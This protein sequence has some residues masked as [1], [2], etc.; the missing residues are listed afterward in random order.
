MEDFL[1]GSKASVI[2]LDKGVEQN[3]KK[4]YTIDYNEGLLS[5]ILEIS[6]STQET[7]PI[8][9][10]AQQVIFN[11]GPTVHG[12]DLRIPSDLTLTT[13]ETKI[14]LNNESKYFTDVSGSGA[15]FLLTS[16]AFSRLNSLFQDSITHYL[17]DSASNKF[18]L[19]IKVPSISG[20]INPYEYNTNEFGLS[21]VNTFELDMNSMKI[22][23]GSLRIES[24]FKSYSNFTFLNKLSNPAVT[25]VSLPTAEFFL[26]FTTSG[27]SSPTHLNPGNHFV[28]YKL[29]PTPS[30]LVN[31]IKDE[32]L[33][34]GI[35]ENGFIVIP[36]N[37]DPKIKYN[38]TK[39]LKDQLGVEIETG[40]VVNGDVSPFDRNN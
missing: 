39:I 7:S 10:N 32:D 20:S 12:I 13:T 17:D 37:I 25:G 38:L 16:N 3:L 26:H 27:Q 40:Y 2:L 6:G 19:E 22:T 33:P 18:F 24:R 14:F 15:N 23:P 35:G 29:N 36:E 21:S 30:I 4:T 34:N 1:I 28:L 31:M 8:I 9:F 11:N 5:R